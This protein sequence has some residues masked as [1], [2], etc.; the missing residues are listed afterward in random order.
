MNPTFDGEGNARFADGLMRTLLNERSVQSILEY[1]RAATGVGLAFFER[2]HDEPTVASED[3]EFAERCVFFPAA[4]IQR[5]YRSWQIV[6]HGIDGYLAADVNFARNGGF[7][8]LVPLI[9]DAILLSKVSQSADELNGLKRREV[10]ARL[11]GASED[12]AGRLCEILCEG[13]PLEGGFYAMSCFVEILDP[14]GNPAREKQRELFAKY[15]KILKSSAL[16]TIHTQVG[17]CF[18]TA[19]FCNERRN[20]DY[21][22]NNLSELFAYYSTSLPRPYGFF[23]RCGIG[24]RG[25]GAADFRR[26]FREAEMAVKHSILEGGRDL[27]V[28]WDALGPLRMLA[29]P[30]PGDES[31]LMHALEELRTLQRAKATPLFS[32]L[33]HLVRNY[34]NITATAE[35]LSLHYNSMKYRYERIEE[36]LGLNLGDERNRFTLSLLVRSLLFDLPMPDFL[37]IVP[38]RE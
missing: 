33:V 36:L 29:D 34:W 25:S 20:F 37:A 31:G 12:E 10:F 19:I 5:L 24:G 1:C 21:I 26:S 16:E 27:Y 2:A 15:V 32:T 22:L 11:L 7:E 38:W 13:L 6:S 8:A 9:V 28:P 18:A 17:D 30:P 4:E 35:R 3:R 14:E 23:A